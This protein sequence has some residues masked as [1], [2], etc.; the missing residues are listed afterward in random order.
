MD[1]SARGDESAEVRGAV[2]ARETS[3]L[4]AG[5]DGHPKALQASVHKC[6]G[7]GKQMVK[8]QRVST[9]RSSEGRADRKRGPGH[10][11]QHRQIVGTEATGSGASAAP[12]LPLARRGSRNQREPGLEAAAIVTENSYVITGSKHFREPG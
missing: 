7:Q 10:P 5:P 9:H 4:S 6:G 8:R 1:Y 3:T 12:V 2:A 11:Q